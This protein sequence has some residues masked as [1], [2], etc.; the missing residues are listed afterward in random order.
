VTMTR[1]DDTGRFGEFGGRFLPESLVPACE[2]LERA[3]DEAWHDDAFRA[4]YNDIL[5]PTAVDPRRSPSASGSPRSS[6][7]A[8][9][10]SAKT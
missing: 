1:P 10:S 8:S 3:F 4:E 6:V 9:S 5:R 2:E 7:Y